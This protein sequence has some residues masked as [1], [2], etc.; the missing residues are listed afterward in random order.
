VTSTALQPITAAQA[1]DEA[2][3]ELTVG[4]NFERYGVPIDKIDIEHFRTALAM[5]LC[6]RKAQGGR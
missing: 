2:V 5:L 3:S 1:L 4:F 6:L